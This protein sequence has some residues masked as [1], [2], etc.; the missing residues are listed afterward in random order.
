MS[1]C[2]FRG[3]PSQ[4]RSFQFCKSGDKLIVCPMP[5]ENPAADFHASRAFLPLLA[6]VI[7]NQLRIEA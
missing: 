2:F 6:Q 7:Q 3:G 5:F 1:L 4:I